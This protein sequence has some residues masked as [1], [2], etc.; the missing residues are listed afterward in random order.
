MDGWV[1]QWT[2]DSSQSF[3]SLFHVFSEEN[4]SICS[5][6]NTYSSNIKA[7]KAEIFYFQ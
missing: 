1:G 3:E 6:F 2:D 4:I 5:T 7:E